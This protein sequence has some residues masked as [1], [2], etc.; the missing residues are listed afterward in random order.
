MGI[1][2]IALVAYRTLALWVTV[3]GLMALIETLFT[4]R[5]VWA[6][7]QAAMV[8]VS[9]PATETDFFW[10]TTSALA[11]RL[12]LGVLLWCAAPTLARYTPFSKL[13]LASEQS[14]RAT[15][16]SAAAF[17]VGV[18]LLSSSIPG[19]AFA[20]L[21]ATRPGVPAYDDGVGGARVAQLLAQLFLGVAFVRG[22]WL[23]DLAISSRAHSADTEE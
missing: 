6:Q 9:N 5:S 1:R 19:L 20:A 2:D 4:W 15:L 22:G 11:S 12:L 18:W 23:V 10:M 21:A 13:P 14:S 7:S 3:S 16:F 8:G 17:L